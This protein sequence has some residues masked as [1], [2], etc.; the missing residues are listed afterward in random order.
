MEELEETKNSQ[1]VSKM[2]SV[3]K[4]QEKT[5]EFYM[6]LREDSSLK[7]FLMKKL[8]LNYAE[9]RVNK[10][11]QIKSHTL[12]HMMVEQLDSHTQI[13][14]FMIQLKLILLQEQFLISLNSKLAML[15][16][17][18]QVTTLEELVLLLQE[19]DT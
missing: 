17:Q 6:T 13:L 2:L 5:S 12:L 1:Q 19:K 7:L 8:N 14:K 4:K 18:H 11:D 9:L 3:L 10:L 16:S 15:S